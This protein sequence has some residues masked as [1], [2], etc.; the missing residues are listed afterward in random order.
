MRA[1]SSRRICISFVRKAIDIIDLK[2]RIREK[3]SKIKVIAKI[4]MPE[5]LKNIRDII[6]ALAQKKPV[7]D[8]ATGEKYQITTKAIH[9]FGCSSSSIRRSHFTYGLGTI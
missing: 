6:V 2:K 9:L 3:E 7:V 5:A 1:L 4:E 8:A